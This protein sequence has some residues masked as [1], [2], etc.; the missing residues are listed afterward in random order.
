MRVLQIVQQP[1]LRGAEVFAF[2]LSDFL[3]S[4]G[5]EV[6]TA[7]LYDSPDGPALPARGDDVFIGARI[8]HIAERAPGINPMVVRRL[9]RV[10]SDFAPDV[11]QANGARTLKYG[12]MVRRFDDVPVI[13]RS[14]GDPLVW[15]R[16]RIKTSTYRHV[17]MP[18]IDG[19]AAVS[20][21][22]LAGLRQLYDLAD[23]VVE[24]IPR[25]VDAGA[26]APTTPK[27][28]VRQH[29]GSDATA[30]VVAFVGNLSVEKRPDRLARVFTDVARDLSDAQLWV[31][32]DGTCEQQLR[33]AVRDTG[34]ADRVRFVGRVHDVGSYLAAA[35]ALILTSDTE[36]LPGV[37]LE[38]AALGTPTISTEVGGVSDAITHGV[39]G[40]LC[41][42]DDERELAREVIRVLRDP[43]LKE[44]LGGSARAEFDRRFSI[45]AVGERYVD[46][47]GT[48]LRRRG[49]TSS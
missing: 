43:A 26:I 40:L 7:Y 27:A 32:G 3:L 5:H 16:G 28:K 22:T 49:L 11:I 29:L 21:H 23:K 44:R 41:A 42:P 38:A 10:V 6:A 47:Y 24:V 18:P 34:V 30:P 31:I 45:E 20:T 13:Y 2:Q 4:S 39:N 8:D 35:D 1:Q 9:R 15:V 37:M 36:G 33:Q 14:I 12:S 46:L 48:T 25:G 17:F 19:I